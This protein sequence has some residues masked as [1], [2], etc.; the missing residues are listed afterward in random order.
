VV[1]L[2]VNQAS[3]TPRINISGFVNDIR[4]YAEHQIRN[5]TTETFN[6]L[7]SGR[8]IEG[9]L[10]DDG[11]FMSASDPGDTI[12]FNYEPFNSTP[13][14]SAVDFT[15]TD[16]SNAKA[17]KFRITLHDDLGD[18]YF[19]LEMAAKDD[20][21]AKNRLLPGRALS[22]SA[23]TTT[24]DTRPAGERRT[25]F[26]TDTLPPAISSFYNT[27][28]TAETAN[29]FRIGKGTFTLKGTVSDTNGVKRLVV[30]QK[31]GGTTLTIYNRRADGTGTPPDSFASDSSNNTWT[32]PNL[33]WD[34]Y[35]T[36]YTGGPID[37]T[38][39]YTIT[40]YDNTEKQS[41]VGWTVRVDSIAPK[42]GPAAAID[43][44]PAEISVTNPV[45]SAGVPWIGDVDAFKGVIYR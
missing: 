28:S 35:N 3:D 8:L 5:T 33:P 26:I 27:E 45:N 31:K 1:T 17:V 44:A 11:I 15:I 37:G 10:E 38:Y 20:L 41:S 29:F 18:G 2:K 14:R 42:L 36:T 43:A 24:D 6:S 16:A 19:T 23:V 12:T 40:A 4:T 32:L 25:F 13:N 21:S 39:E 22:E 9:T 7:T 34:S 30:T